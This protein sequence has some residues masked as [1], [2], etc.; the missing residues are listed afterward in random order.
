MLPL[1]L[2]LYA[3]SWPEIKWPLRST[4][5]ESFTRG[6]EV[7]FPVTPTGETSSRP[8]L[9][10]FEGQGGQI[11]ASSYIAS[12]DYFS[13]INCADRI[14]IAR[15]PAAK[16]NVDS[17]ILSS[18]F[19][20]TLLPLS[21][22]LPSLLNIYLLADEMSL[23]FLNKAKK[24]KRLSFGIITRIPKEILMLRRRQFTFWRG[25]T[26]VP[27]TVNSTY[28]PISKDLVTACVIVRN[29]KPPK[30]FKSKDRIEVKG[31]TLAFPAPLAL[32]IC[33]L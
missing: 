15:N 32:A 17:F 29:R 26:W 7:I 16:A 2:Q 12:G 24:K 31:A 20:F 28:I 30:L 19:S 23:F 18:F 1:H 13:F 4:K 6:Q 22:L 3:H 25:E 8:C 14:R 9:S 5:R 33:D 27:F 21:H 10:W 11:C